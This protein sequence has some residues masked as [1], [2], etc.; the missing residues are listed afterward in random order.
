MNLRNRESKSGYT[1]L[2]EPSL[3]KLRHFL[4]EHGDGA[5]EKHFGVNKLTIA[6]AAA[7][8]NIQHGSAVVI[9]QGLASL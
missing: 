8:L 6:R 5:A 7:G 4:A 1:S 3:I 9:R 2:D